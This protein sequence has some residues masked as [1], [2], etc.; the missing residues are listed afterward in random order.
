M[1]EIKNVV[2]KLTNS[3]MYYLFLSSRELF[4]SNFWCWLKTINESETIKL[5]SDKVFS[6]KTTFKREHNQS[7]D[8]I[9]SKIDLFIFNTTESQSIVVENKVKDFPTLNQL[10][11]IKD[12]FGK[13]KPELVLVTLFWSN[14]FIFKD[15]KIITYKEI[16]NSIN[17][18]KFTSDLYHQNLI[19]DYKNFT[20]N[21][22]SLAEALEINKVYDF[23]VSHNKYLFQE[24]DSIK[25]WEGYQKMR[26]SHLISHF[27]KNNKHNLICDYSI[28]HQKAT[29]DF[30]LNVTNK[31]SVGLSIE[32]NQY[33]KVVCGPNALEFSE[34]LMA[35]DVFFNN[36]WTSAKNL[37]ICGY[38][39]KWQYQYEQIDN[40]FT[41][42]TL[43]EKINKD[44]EVINKDLNKIIQNIPDK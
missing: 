32:D 31:Y 44:F 42:E 37:K 2:E 6:S 28:N 12:S 23:A 14:D 34:N 3:P 15:W 35:A 40:L 13:F 36:N 9:K 7:Y 29:I 8:A 16:S 1:I 33:R 20:F 39:P 22:A 30:Y 10:D 21:L 27:L 41:Y 19:Q 17:P 43:F 38:K 26:A 24:L 18:K 5:F 25:L 11:R 4:H